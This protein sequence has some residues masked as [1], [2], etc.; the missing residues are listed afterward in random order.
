MVSM[1]GCFGSMTFQCAGRTLLFC[2]IDKDAPNRLFLKKGFELE[3]RLGR[4]E[5]SDVPELAVTTTDA[6]SINSPSS[7]TLS[8]FNWA[9]KSRHSVLGV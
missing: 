8:S 9:T 7:L 5:H 3:T 6:S 1:I 4:P 2:S